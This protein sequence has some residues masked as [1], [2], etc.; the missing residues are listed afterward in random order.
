MKEKIRSLIEQEDKRNPFTDEYLAKKVNLHREKVTIIRNNLGIQCSRD[1]RKIELMKYLKDLVSKNPHYNKN[2]IT[3]EIN[4]MGFKI[5]RFAITQYLKE[6]EKNEVVN[7]EVIDQARKHKRSDESMEAQG[8]FSILIGKNG[9]LKTAIKLAKAAVLYPPHGLHTIITGP[10]GV[11]KSELAECIYRFAIES[12]RFDEN[13][14][15]IIFNA[16]D[17]AENP[18]L[19]ISQLFGHVKGAF[20]GADETKEGLAGKAD[21]GILFIDEVHRL[22]S[23]G[24]EILFQLIDK[25]KVRKLGETKLTK[26]VEV[27]IVCATSESLD[28]YLLNTFKRRIPVAIEIPDLSSRSFKER[29]DIINKFFVVEAQRMGAQIHIKSDVLKGLMLYKCPGNIGQLRSDIQVACARGLL[30]QLSNKDKNVIINISELPSYVKQGLIEIRNSREKIEKYVKGDLEVDPDSKV[31]IIKNQHDIYHFPKEIYRYIEE[32]HLTLLEE[33]FNPEIINRIV[34]GELEI[35]IQQYVKQ[36]EDSSVNTDLRDLI[37][38]VGNHIID[39]TEEIVKLAE[40]RLKKLDANLKMCLAI[41]LK[42]AFERIRS[43]KTISNAHLKEI[44]KNYPLEFSVAQ[45][46]AQHLKQKYEISLPEDEIGFL[47][48]YL[49]TRS[50]DKIYNSP[51]VGVLIIAHGR[52]ASAVAEVSNKL[53]GVNHAKALDMSLDKDPEE[54]LERA[55]QVVK[56]IDEGKGVILLVDMGS[57][58]FFG[59]MIANKTGIEVRSISQVS[60]VL[61]IEVIRRSVIPDLNIIEIVDS[62]NEDFIIENRANQ[63]M[64]DFK[65]NQKKPVIVAVCVTGMG[66][67][68]K[69]KEI[70]IDG[71]PDIQDKID[72]ETIGIIDFPRLDLEIKRIMRRNKVLAIVGTINPIISGIPF[73][74]VYDIK[75]GDKV[76]E[77]ENL[78]NIQTNHVNRI[79]GRSSLRGLVREEYIYLDLVAE[80]KETVIGYMCNKL[81]DAGIVGTD[82][83]DDVLKREEVLSTELMDGVAIPHTDGTN[84]NESVI[85]IGIL[86]EPIKWD[87]TYVDIVL[88]LAINQQ[89]FD[90]LSIFLPFVDTKEFKEIKKLKSSREIKEAILIGSQP[91]NKS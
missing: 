24:Q 32:R 72:I 27:M 86:R 14:P 56:K 22:P 23:E 10:T 36:V 49:K 15:F 4:E 48:I 63:G 35:R 3:R 73:Y 46:I 42:S 68:L 81:E 70:I 84:V 55:V 21:G 88:L 87:N 34:G 47:T 44:I 83:Y 16:S 60:T 26:K 28:S 31:D 29:F 54:M 89:C 19:L 91:V 13:A 58:V 37:S 6:I 66:T 25:G 74:S 82:F 11:G 17:Y 8:A 5:S 78:I 69:I 80:S 40:T 75:S 77:L 39:V 79:E 85:V 43:G 71:I 76:K 38:I 52:V 12:N 61:A 1:R 67:A 62:I 51:K 50:Y 7:E 45:E 65:M 9:S 30:N 57:L 59:D 33:G 41:H 53:L 90:S 64:D 18:Q 2:D 20:T